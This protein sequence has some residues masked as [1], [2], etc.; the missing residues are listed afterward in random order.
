MI[1]T[2]A[3]HFFQPAFDRIGWG[4]VRLK[5]RPTQI[6]VAAFLLGVSVGPAIVFYKLGTALLLLWISGLLDV[7][8]G[9]VARLT[10]K[11]SKAGAFMDLIMDRMVE[12]AVIIGF[13]V[14]FPQHSLTYI[15][16]LTMVIF[17]FSTFM[18]AGALFQ[19]AGIKSMHYDVGIVER[20]ETFL[21]FSLM[22]LFPEYLNWML[23]GFNGLILC[24]GLI[25]FRKLIRQ[26][27]LID[28]N[29][30]EQI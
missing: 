29:R 24:T 22:L 23:M 5:I 11:S 28:E 13:A 7:L 16:F 2:K 20:T 12:A 27:R 10:G 17:N 8:D 19:N 9:S 6:T 3:R 25:R 30:M 4:L 26:A 15:I 1:D 21:V 18:A 14:S